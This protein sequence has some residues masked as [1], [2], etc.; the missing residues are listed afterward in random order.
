MKN[1]LI[2]LIVMASMSVK[3]QDNRNIGDFNEVKV[4]DQITVVLMKSDETRA[5]I[6]GSRKSDVEIVNKNGQL[7]IRMRL[8]RLLDGEDVK[9]T[10]YYKE[11][12]SVD[13]SEGSHIESSETMKLPKIMITAKEGA[14]IELNL[15]VQNADVKSVTGAIVRLA[16]TAENLK[17]SLGT[18]GILEAEPLQTEQADVSINAGG[19]AK[20]T[21]SD[22]VDASVKAGG[23]IKI[24]GHPKQVNKKTA[25]GG[26]ITVV[27]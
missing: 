19:E 22:L 2:A 8:G 5:E 18:G 23:E 3:A 20:I 24:Y 6:S 21:A 14:E 16:G 12:H 7:K 27:K 9:V 10:L 4:F 11:L 26:D 17:A 13:A 25:L 15:D 1:L